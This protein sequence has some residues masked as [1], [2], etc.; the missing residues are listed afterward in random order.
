MRIL[1]VDDEE[2]LCEALK[3]FFEY[4]GYE[5]LTSDTGNGALDIVRTKS[6]DLVLLDIR[7]P[8]ISGVDVLSKIK[9][10]NPQVKVVVI[11]GG[12]DDG[13]N[14]SKCLQLG[15]CE[16]VTKPFTIGYLDKKLLP[17]VKKLMEVDEV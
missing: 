12:L 8:D 11:T 13:E 10:T 14:L 7:L 2:E 4:R 16:Y 9:M 17:K 6:P 3:D 5:V 1:I 15:A